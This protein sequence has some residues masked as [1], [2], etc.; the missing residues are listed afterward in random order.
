M[1]LAETKALIITMFAFFCLN[2]F[3]HD[4]AYI[5]VFMKIKNSYSFVQLE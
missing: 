3:S 4:V 1:Y 2:M 5:N